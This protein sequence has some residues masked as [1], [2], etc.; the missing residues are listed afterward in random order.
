MVTRIAVA[1]FVTAAVASSGASASASPAAAPPSQEQVERGKSLVWSIA[2]N[3]CHTPKKPGPRGPELDETRLLSGHR[4]SP[5]LPAP[6]AL[7]P[8]PWGVTYTA[9]LTP[10]P[11]TGLGLW[12]EQMFIRALRLGRHMGAS[13]PIQ[14]PMPWEVY[15]RLSDE[16]LKAIFAYLRS[17][18]PV[19]N[20]V[21]D[22]VIAEPAPQD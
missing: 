3:D 17:I 5:A 16:D 22:P 2:C 13:R 14:P 10:D 6:P 4:E 21:P 1:V 9:N 18:P 19:K 8:G 20:R 7:P 11:E 15:G 12:T